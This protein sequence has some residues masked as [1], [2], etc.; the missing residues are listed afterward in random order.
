MQMQVCNTSEEIYPFGFG[1]HPYFLIKD[2]GSCSSLKLPEGYKIQIDE[3][4]IPTGEKE[5]YDDFLNL[6]KI[7]NSNFDTGF[8]L[9]LNGKTSNVTL[10]DDNKYGLN[11]WQ[12]SGPGEFRFLQVF[13]PPDRKSIALEPMT[14]NIDAFNNKEGV[15]MLEPQEKRSLRCGVRVD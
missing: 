7:D 14:C 1:W 6:C 11:F 9:V 2:S 12:E 3:F 8:E 15:W 4:M 10:Q 5:S 13:I